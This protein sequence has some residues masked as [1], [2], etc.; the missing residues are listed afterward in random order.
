MVVVNTVYS[1]KY[2]NILQEA[3]A[4]VA[5]ATCCFIVKLYQQEAMS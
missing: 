4:V 3:A 2:L 1:V 5:V